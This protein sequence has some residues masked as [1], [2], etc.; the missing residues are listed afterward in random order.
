MCLGLLQK[1]PSG[2]SFFPSESLLNTVMVEPC[3]A[4]PGVRETLLHSLHI[5]EDA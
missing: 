5:K 4:G 2:A 3:Q 1:P